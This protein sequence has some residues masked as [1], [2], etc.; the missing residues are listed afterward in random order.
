MLK[1]R[2]FCGAVI[3]AALCLSGPSRAELPGS[4]EEI[5][6]LLIGATVPELTLRS[7]DGSGFDLGKAIKKQPTIL[8]FYRGGW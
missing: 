6:P 4:A 1:T 8:I 3:V 2:V 5:R 7:A